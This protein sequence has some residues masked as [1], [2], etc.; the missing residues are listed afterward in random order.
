MARYPKRDTRQNA[1][2]TL[3]LRGYRTLRVA[4]WEA[5]AFAGFARSWLVAP[6]QGKRIAESGYR[7]R[8][9]NW[10]M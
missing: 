7:P 10:L 3:L 1:R 2:S 4:G 5:L 6:L 8:A 9:I